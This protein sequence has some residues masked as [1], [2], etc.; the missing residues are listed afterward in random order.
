MD[1]VRS[2]SMFIFT[3]VT[4]YKIHILTDLP[5]MAPPVLNAKN[6]IPSFQT[7]IYLLTNSIKFTSKCD[8]C[9]V[10]QDLLN[11][12]RFLR[13][14]RGLL[15]FVD[16]DPILCYLWCCG[17]FCPFLFQNILCSI[18]LCLMLILTPFDSGFLPRK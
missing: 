2:T 11:R 12:K 8:H 13:S 1:F 17:G 5:N 4:F 18:V 7:K 6:Q 10:K 9:I 3:E 16:N 14:W 15:I